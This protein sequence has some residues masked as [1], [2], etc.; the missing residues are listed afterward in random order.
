MKNGNKTKGTMEIISMQIVHINNFS[1]IVEHIN[2][3][4]N[5]DLYQL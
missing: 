4:P 5:Y 2:G 3:Q 1:I